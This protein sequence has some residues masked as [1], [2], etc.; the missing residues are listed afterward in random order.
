[1]TAQHGIGSFLMD[2]GVDEVRSFLK[3]AL[4]EFYESIAIMDYREVWNHRHGDIFL[5]LSSD[6]VEDSLRRMA[7]AYVDKVKMDDKGTVNP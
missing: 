6:F 2:S 7:Q 4:G 3:W 1:M 5:I